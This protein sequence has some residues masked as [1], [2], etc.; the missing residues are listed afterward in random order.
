MEGGWESGPAIVPGDV[1]SSLLI[2]AVRYDDG[3]LQMPPDAPS[4]REI[5]RLELWGHAECPDPARG[6]GVASQSELPTVGSRRRVVSTG[7]LLR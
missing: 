4:M 3:D 7:R 2:R 6:L 1:E 5:A